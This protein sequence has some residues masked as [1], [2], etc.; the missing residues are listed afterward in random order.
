MHK[1]QMPMLTTMPNANADAKC[2]RK[3]AFQTQVFRGLYKG[4]AVAVKELYGLMRMANEASYEEI[5][6]ELSVLNRL[7]HPNLLLWYGVV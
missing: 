5:G 7:R 2:E 3:L 6:T 1:C 4:T